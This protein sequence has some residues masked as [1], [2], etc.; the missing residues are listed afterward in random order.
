MKEPAALAPVDCSWARAAAL[1]LV[2]EADE[3]LGRGQDLVGVVVDGD[4]ELADVEG[5]LAQHV[6]RAVDEGFAEG[7]VGDE[8]MPIMRP[9]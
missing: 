8:K 3:V 1:P 9:F 4:P 2:E 5:A 6:A 7:A